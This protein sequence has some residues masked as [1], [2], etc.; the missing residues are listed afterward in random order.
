MKAAQAINVIVIPLLVVLA[1]V[2]LAVM[3]KTKAQS[4][5]VSDKESHDDV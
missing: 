5:T 4:R 2:F 1:G 3:R